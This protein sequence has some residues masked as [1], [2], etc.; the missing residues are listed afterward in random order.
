MLPGAITD[1]P[2]YDQKLVRGR[3]FNIS[4]YK[5]RDQRLEHESQLVSPFKGENN[6]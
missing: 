2:N 1:K 5:S 6:L 4:V 3:V